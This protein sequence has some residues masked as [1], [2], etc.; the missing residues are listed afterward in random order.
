MAVAIIQARM[1]SSRLPGK[2]LLPLGDGTALKCMVDRVR[3]AETLEDAVVATSTDP[4]DDAIE[5]EC[6]IL[7]IRCLRGDL[8]DVLSRF[9]M[10]AR[11]V[12]NASGV[13]VRLTADCPL[14]CPEI[15]DATVSALVRDGA[16][17]ISNSIQPTYPRGLDAEA[18]TA[19]ALDRA[20]TSALTDF[21]REH[22]TTWMIRH[23]R[24][25][26]SFPVLEPARRDWRLTIDHPEDY[27]VVWTIH[28]AIGAHGNSFTFDELL[29]YLD[30]HTKLAALNSHHE[31][32]QVSD[33][34]DPS[35]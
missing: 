11:N 22:V 6:S 4:S 2:V 5:A 17:Y 21:D 10:V 7:G 13:W 15:I 26:T 1:S 14:I 33:R 31:A 12:S 20:Y 34:C 3:M 35:N 16:D 28:N 18:F 9:A 23:L 32:S 25:G 19:D 27:E 29:A 30:T 8:D 24:T